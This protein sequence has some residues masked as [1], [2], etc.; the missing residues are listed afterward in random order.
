MHINGDRLYQDLKNHFKTMKASYDTTWHMMPINWVDD[1]L[2]TI[3]TA[4][5]I[6][7]LHTIIELATEMGFDL[8]Q[9]KE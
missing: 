6:G 5:D 9:Y 7:D 3:D 2:N 1:C 4:Y 8:N